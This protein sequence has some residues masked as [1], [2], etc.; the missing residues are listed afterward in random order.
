MARALLA[1][2]GWDLVERKWM[3]DYFKWNIHRFHCK[4]KFL[5]IPLYNTEKMV[6]FRAIN[7]SRQA[8]DMLILKPMSEIYSAMPVEVRTKT[9]CKFLSLEEKELMKISSRGRDQ[10]N[11]EDRQLS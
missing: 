2:S 8:I 11:G 9:T 6:L 4:G 7:K 1:R 5:N 10:G 3:L